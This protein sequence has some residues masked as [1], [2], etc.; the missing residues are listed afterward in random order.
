[1]SYFNNFKVFVSTKKNLYPVSSREWIFV[2]CF[3]IFFVFL[4]SLLTIFLAYWSI[5]LGKSDSVENLYI[6]NLKD[7]DLLKNDF[8]LIKD[9]SSV[10][11][12]PNLS[13]SNNVISNLD[14][15][16]QYLSQTL[17]GS[18]LETQV[19]PEIVYGILSLMLCLSFVS[20]LLKES[21]KKEAM[22]KVKEK[23]DDVDPKN[24]D[25]DVKSDSVKSDSLDQGGIEFE[26]PS[27]FIGDPDC[28]FLIVF[29]RFL[30][31]IFFN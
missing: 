5:H 26:D 3:F 16:V 31:E 4:N 11:D 14:N 22:D 1:M 9:A 15:M 24:S 27:A 19:A 13:V 12:S 7:R 2:Y 25:V 29:A 30:Y 20:S 21:Q 17:S 18:G 23:I 28:F 8:T 10:S 6:Q